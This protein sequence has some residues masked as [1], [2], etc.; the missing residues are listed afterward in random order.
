MRMLA[1]GLAAVVLLAAA[2]VAIAFHRDMDAA[3]ARLQGRSELVATSFGA[4]EVAVHGAG[5]A[6]LVLHGSGGGFDQGE[7]LADA[8]LGDAVRRIVPSRFGYL[9]SSLQPGAGFDEQAQAFA[10][11]LD[12]LGIERVAVVAFS[13]GGPSALLFAL[14]HP[15]RVSSLTLLSAGV[16]ASAEAGQHEAD[17]RG[18]ALARIFQSDFGYW[19][20]THALRG[21][22]LDLMGVDAAVVAGLTPAQRQLADDLIDVMNPVA[23]RAAGAAFDHH[24]ALPDARIAGIRAPT[25]VV[26]AADDTLQRFH[27][28]EFAARTI[29]GARLLRFERG[30]HLV[31][32]VEREAIRAQVLRHVLA[33][34]G[35]PAA[36]GR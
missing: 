7:F 32:A 28:A 20:L 36:A 9:R 25:L 34:A 15:Q 30:G 27:N 33:H 21:T 24:A 5:P 22:F 4:V 3:Y 35:D 19:A 11:L 8:V 13:H 10:E 1:P 17:R 29:P 31:V 26:H 2:A 23:P 18:A 6:V 16:A 14:R 12:R